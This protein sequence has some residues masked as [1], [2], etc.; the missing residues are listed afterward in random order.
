M[1]DFDDELSRLVRELNALGGSASLPAVE[2]DDAGRLRADRL[3][4]RALEAGASDLLVVP[5]APATGRVDGQLLALDP[6]VL[7]ARTVR[8]LILEILDE[9]SMRRLDERLAVDFA[10]DRGGLGRFRANVHHQRGQVAMAVRPL[11][12]RVPDPRALGL[13]ASVERFADLERG[14]VLIAGP[15]GSGKTTTLACMVG[16]MNRTRSLHVITIE[17]P[18]EHIHPHGTCLVEQIEVGSD[19]PSFADA[20]RNAV[21]QDPDVIVVGEM[22]DP[23]TM[24][25]ALTAAETGH[26]VLSSLHTGT[27]AQT[28]DRIVDSFPDE[29]QPQIRAQLSLTLNGIVIQHLIPRREGRG[30]VAA[31]EVLVVTDGVRNL[32]RRGLNHQ[33]TAQMAMGRQAGSVTLDLALARLV[34]D[35]SISREQGL[36]RAAHPEEFEGFLR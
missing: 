12:D 33:L 5:G 3:L 19:V 23:E 28:L 22:R 21:R 13:P 8:S 36:R 20:L 34:Q 1:P 32:L 25:M 7:D 27:V 16:V 6:Q 10:F 17:D 24:A 15:A 2:R 18:V 14:L 30:R 9:K 26:L 31:V 4:S 35:G 29:R 11:P